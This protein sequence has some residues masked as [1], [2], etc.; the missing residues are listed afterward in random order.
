MGA[1]EGVS[2]KDNKDDLKKSKKG[3][4]ELQKL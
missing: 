3:K 1:F 4:K 2:I